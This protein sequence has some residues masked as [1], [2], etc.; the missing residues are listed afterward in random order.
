[1]PISASDYFRDSDAVISSTSGLRMAISTITR[2]ADDRGHRLFWRGQANHEWGLVSSLARRLAAIETIDDPL[3]N[4]VEKKLLGEGTAWIKALAHPTYAEPLAKLAYLQHHGIPTRLLD[5]TSDPW[6]AV[7]FAAETDDRLD[8]RLFALIV[9]AGDVLA[10]TPAGAPWER[11]RTDEI[12]IYDAT[13]SGVVFDRIEAQR[14]VLAV[15]RLPSTKP[16]RQAWDGV[17]EKQRSLLAEEVRRILSIP[18][19]LSKFD[20][21]AKAPIPTGAKLPIGLTMRI[22]IDKA[23]LRR[24]VAGVARGRHI[25]P[26]GANATHRTMYPDAAGMVANSEVIRGLSRGVLFLK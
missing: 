26:K 17:L 3:L 14:G 25:A 24:D 11:Y 4:R 8:G 22:H 21:S 7:F 18:F 6:T 13:A 9:D 15:A 12:K 20:P 19:K 2:F 10:A 16:H 23:S 5:F 1:M